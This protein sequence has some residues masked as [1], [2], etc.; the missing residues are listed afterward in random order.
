[1][2]LFNVIALCSRLLCILCLCFLCSISV[3]WLVGPLFDSVRPDYKWWSKVE[4]MTA[5]QI[6][7]KYINNKKN[8]RNEETRNKKLHCS[9]SAL[10][11]SSIYLGSSFPCPTLWIAMEP[12][13]YTCYQSFLYCFL[14]LFRFV[15]ACLHKFIPPPPYYCVSLSPVLCASPYLCSPGVCT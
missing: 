9:H 6:S 4:A 14:L 12:R 2:G 1:M 13:G 10:S 5:T 11:E 7:K 15:Y 3:S 8:E